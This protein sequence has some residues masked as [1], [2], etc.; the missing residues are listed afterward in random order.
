M[1]FLK[2]K[3][4]P[5][6]LKPE[7]VSYGN[8]FKCKEYRKLDLHHRVKRRNDKANKYVVYLCRTCHSWV[9]THPFKASLIGLHIYYYDTDEYKRD[10]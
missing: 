5:S 4:V 8:C 7:K 10:Y 9:E 3:S 6:L 1:K 2:I